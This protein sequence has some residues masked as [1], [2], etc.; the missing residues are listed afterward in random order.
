MLL[1]ANMLKISPAVDAKYCRIA[2]SNLNFIN[3]EDDVMLSSYSERDK[4]NPCKALLS[5]DEFRALIK[6]RYLT[7]KERED[8]F[9]KEYERVLHTLDYDSLIWGLCATPKLK[10]DIDQFCKRKANE[11]KCSKNLI[12]KC[13]DEYIKKHITM[14]NCNEYDNVSD[15]LFAAMHQYFDY[16]LQ[17]SGEL[18]KF[19]MDTSISAMDSRTFAE[20]S[21]ANAIEEDEP[22]EKGTV[23]INDTVS[24]RELI[25]MANAASSILYKHRPQ[26]SSIDEIYYDLVSYKMNRYIL[27]TKVRLNKCSDVNKIPFRFVVK[28]KNLDLTGE[29]YYGTKEP[30]KKDRDVRLNEL[31][32]F[33]INNCITRFNE[34]FNIF[35]S[36]EHSANSN[37]NAVHLIEGGKLDQ[38]KLKFLCCQLL[39]S[40]LAL[41]KLE[42]K[43]K[44][45]GLNIFDLPVGL[46]RLQH[47]SFYTKNHIVNPM[48]YITPNMPIKDIITAYET[49]AILAEMRTYEDSLVESTASILERYTESDQIELP[50]VYIG[51]ELGLINIDK[52][53]HYQKARYAIGSNVD[54]INNRLEEKRHNFLINRKML[55]L[56]RLLED[57]A[58]IIKPLTRRNENKGVYMSTS[59]AS[60]EEIASFV[61]D[62]KNKCYTKERETVSERVQE[63]GS[64]ESDI[65]YQFNSLIEAYAIKGKYGITHDSSGVASLSCFSKIETLCEDEDVYFSLNR[66]YDFFIHEPFQ[67]NGSSQ[68]ILTLA[69]IL[70]IYHKCLILSDI[71]EALIGQHYYDDPIFFNNSQITTLE[72]LE[73][74]TDIVEL[75]NSLEAIQADKIKVNDVIVRLER[76]LSSLNS[77]VNGISN[78]N[79]YSVYDREV[80]ESIKKISIDSGLR[81][82]WFEALY[83]EFDKVEQFKK[84]QEKN[85]VST[86]KVPFSFSDF[87]MNKYYLYTGK[88][89]ASIV[90]IGYWLFLLFNKERVDLLRNIYTISKSSLNF[91]D[92]MEQSENSRIE[93]LL[94][95]AAK[96]LPYLCLEKDVFHFLDSRGYL[97]SSSGE[98]VNEIRFNG[99]IAYR[100]CSGLLVVVNPKMNTY[101]IEKKII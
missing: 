5:R 88:D 49:G 86:M 42:D 85:A 69:G 65:Q 99:D 21:G 76:F 71:G 54:A 30:K 92:L 19:S 96:E 64:S 77:V 11:K 26:G 93:A 41:E 51:D 58:S 48:T 87:S 37:K 100:H 74:L 18:N 50:L 66:W 90:C 20:V 8:A 16:H 68:D 14:R 60:K 35:M 34:A 36:H 72:V 94:T 29:A 84:L 78:Y 57:A 10:Q 67:Y 61:Y 53:R 82:Y 22:N 6:Q 75:F 40:I 59:Y 43:L 73:G 97:K 44:L 23:S 62:L 47:E 80:R 89:A 63:I 79:L 15:F 9:N 27:E 38:D 2:L 7:S 4:F 31:F 55:Q 52:Q 91:S 17:D 70:E 13:A 95:R 83:Y 24:D 32:A 28:D 25:K 56:F 81:N 33:G 46:F 101:T 3:V 98:Y 12:T 39:F 1:Y 45:S